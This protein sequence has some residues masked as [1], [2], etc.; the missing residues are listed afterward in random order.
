[1]GYFVLF[2]QIACHCL[3]SNTDDKKPE[4][5]TKEEEEDDADEQVSK[6]QQCI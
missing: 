5:A 2:T 6:A 4:T 3:E 1:M